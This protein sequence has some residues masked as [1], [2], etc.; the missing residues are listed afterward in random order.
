MIGI[1][2]ISAHDLDD[3]YGDENV[4]IIDL[5]DREIGRAHV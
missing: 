1:E 3:Y 4:M 5:R 2:T